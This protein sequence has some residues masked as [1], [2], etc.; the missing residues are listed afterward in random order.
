MNMCEPCDTYFKSKKT[1]FPSWILANNL[2][3]LPL[4]DYLSDIRD[5]EIQLV[6]DRQ[7]SHNIATISAGSTDKNT[8]LRSHVYV[9]GANPTLA[10]ATLPVDMF[11]SKAFNVSIVGAYTSDIKALVSKTYEIRPQKSLMLLS[12]CQERKNASIISKTS[13][14]LMKDIMDLASGNYSAFLIL[15][16][17]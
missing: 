13:H 12:L 17:V 16:R 4:P 8:F 9:Y 2:T 15:C 6:T 3:L 10:I 1:S 7:R 5:T 11:S 14:S